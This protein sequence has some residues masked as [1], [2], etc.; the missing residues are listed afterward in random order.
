M[1]KSIG[2]SNEA[3]IQ[4]LDKINNWLMAINIES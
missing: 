2:Q 3:V 1:N 4:L